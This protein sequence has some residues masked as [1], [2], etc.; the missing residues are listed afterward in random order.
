MTLLEFIA[1]RFVV[2]DS[3]WPLGELPGAEICTWFSSA[4]R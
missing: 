4:I 3:F 2:D 1:C